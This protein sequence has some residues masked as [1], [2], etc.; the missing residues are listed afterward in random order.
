MQVNDLIKRVYEVCHEYETSF[1]ISPDGNIEN[2]YH[3]TREEGVHWN[4]HE[5]NKII[6]KM[7]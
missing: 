7:L 5:K 1:A 4:F 3:I 2:N 6:Q